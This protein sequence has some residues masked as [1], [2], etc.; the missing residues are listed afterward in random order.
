MS[1]SLSDRYEP[2]AGVQFVFSSWWIWQPFKKPT[3]KAKMARAGSVKAADI[4]Y[5]KE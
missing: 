4:N 3:K 1:G 5:F 2:W